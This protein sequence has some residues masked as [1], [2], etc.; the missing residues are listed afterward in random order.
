[1]RGN[2]HVRFGRRPGETDP[3]RD[4]HRAPGRP[5]LGRAV[6]DVRRRRQQQTLGRRGHRDDPLYRGRRLLHRRFST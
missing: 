3:S 2:A 4:E 5:H 1:M 6:D